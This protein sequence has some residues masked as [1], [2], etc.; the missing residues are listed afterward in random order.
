[1]NRFL[2]ALTLMFSSAVSAT[3]VTI[4]DANLNYEHAY[5]VCNI[6]FE[7]NANPEKYLYATCGQYAAPPKSAYQGD[8]TSVPYDE[9]GVNGVNYHNCK[10]VG[11][12][13][14]EIRFECNAPKISYVRPSVPWYNNCF[15]FRFYNNVRM[16][17]DFM[18]Q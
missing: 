12:G 4:V 1:M 11:D 8:W 6:N 5:S 14:L 16:D 15:G 10:M 3:N 9:I 13:V 18:N 7:S 2:I 17:F